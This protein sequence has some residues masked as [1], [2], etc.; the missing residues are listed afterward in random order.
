MTGAHS[1][2]P[3]ADVPPPP[4][5]LPR[6]ADPRDHGPAKEKRD[7]DARSVDDALDPLARHAAQL[8]PPVALGAFAPPAAASPAAAPPAPVSLEELLPPLVRKLALAGDGK[9][10]TV[11][12]EIGAGALAGATLVVS[13]ETGGIR[14]DVEAPSLASAGDRE[15]W[16]ARLRGRLE[17]KGLR[18]DA[19]RIT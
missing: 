6:A 13:N 4:A 11:R 18:V 17:A 9:R 16:T 19:I 14:V 3:K 8:A 1:P 2:F 15:A 10:A 12:V 5:P 7:D